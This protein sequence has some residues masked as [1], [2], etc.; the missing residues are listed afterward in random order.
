MNQ[1]SVNI[2]IL[3][4]DLHET[5]SFHDDYFRIKIWFWLAREKNRCEHVEIIPAF[6]LW[7]ISLA[8]QNLKLIFDPKKFASR[9][10]IHLVEIRL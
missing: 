2:D 4:V 3:K 6:S 5:N 9:E 8:N 7:N 10:L 1:W